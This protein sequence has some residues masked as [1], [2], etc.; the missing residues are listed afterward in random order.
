ME[1]ISQTCFRP[2]PAPARGKFNFSVFTGQERNREGCLGLLVP[3]DTTS[4]LLDIS[5]R[6]M[7]EMC[8][9]NYKCQLRYFRSV[10]SGGLCRGQAR[11]ACWR[12][13]NVAGAAGCLSRSWPQ[14]FA[15]QA[16]LLLLYPHRGPGNTETEYTNIGYC[17]CVLY[18]EIQRI[19][20]YL[21]FAH[22][23]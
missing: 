23:E 14:F 8:S 11:P 21:G 18:V 16:R 4:E 17:L 13:W 22:F 19:S 1:L 2:Q 6:V 15:R 12:K 10:F 7:R 3:T 5:G 20:F 9:D